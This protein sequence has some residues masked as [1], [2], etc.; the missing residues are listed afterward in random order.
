MLNLI[1][2]FFAL[3]FITAAFMILFEHFLR[4]FMTAPTIPCGEMMGFFININANHCDDK[5]SG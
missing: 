5:T 3:L 1:N 2:P 4:A